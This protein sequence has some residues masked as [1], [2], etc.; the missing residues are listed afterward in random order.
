MGDEYFKK[1][2]TGVYHLLI[3]V[4]VAS[5]DFYSVIGSRLLF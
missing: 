2:F 1:L 4:G 3:C 5:L